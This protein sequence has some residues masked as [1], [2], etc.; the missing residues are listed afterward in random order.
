MCGFTGF[1]DSH[2]QLSASDIEPIAQKMQLQLRDRGPDSS[3]IWVDP[4]DGIAMTHRR[5]A[6][7]DL[8]EHGHQPMLSHDGRY[9]L[10]FNGEIFNAEELREKL[11]SRGVK[12]RGHADTEILLEACAHYGVKTTLEQC[13]GM[14]AIALWDRQEKT[15]T[16]A[17][18]R[19]GKK[20]L[21]WGFQNRILFFGS[22][23]K[24]FFVHPSWQNQLDF[25]ATTN[26]FRYGYVPTTQSIFKHLAQV[27]PGHLIHLRHDA[28]PK[29]E[30]YWSL[31]QHFHPDRKIA[32]S[33][34]QS[35]IEDELHDLLVDTVKMRMH[36]DV[37]IGSFLSGGIDSS[38]VTALMQA[39]HPTPIHTFSIGFES[40]P[41]NEAPYAE[42]VAHY[43]GTEH[44]T[45]YVAAHEVRDVIDRL[46]EIY[47]EPFADSS[48]I[49]TFLVAQF[50]KEKV[51]V[52]LSGDGGDESF[53]GYNRYWMAKMYW[54]KVE[55]IPYILRRSLMVAQ[56]LP[57]WAWSWLS[58]LHSKRGILTPDK[59]QRK[60]GALCSKN[61]SEFYRSLVLSL[62]D[63]AFLSKPN[64]A[65]DPILS[66]GS[67]LDSLDLVE[68]MQLIDLQTYLPG[69][70][71][72]KVDRASMAVGLEARA[73]L[74]DHRLIE[75]ATQLPL[76]YKLRGQEGKWI[77]RNV[78]ARY[79]PRHLF[80]RPKMGFG[81][82][83]AEWLRGPLRAW[84]EPL[85]HDTTTPL[86]EFL[87][88]HQIQRCW[89]EHLSG[90]QEWHYPLWTVLMFQSWCHYWNIRN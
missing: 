90:Q 53:A 81:I 52:V 20:P 55:K 39:Q 44:H 5:L 61:A 8:S 14:F 49:P 26:Y 36:A 17:R 9:V 16:L 43:L 84:A 29:I 78:L 10:I 62:H 83:L 11:I 24:S 58:R 37:P 2:H 75:F 7:M 88:V 32:T 85:I 50:A 63:D 68:R 18:D 67:K 33:K 60:L 80:E 13:I 46:P 57:S 69:D 15:L 35:T 73:P 72:V 22:Q 86:S 30:A 34:S 54:S 25:S 89:K 4:A 64:P 56:Y 6:I 38:L 87:N 45:H 70:I 19:I 12:F 40:Q 66:L 1:W 74:L 31:E 41:Y 77:L 65:E 51:K 76:E 28:S 48:Q 27:P 82:P 42:K 3:G 79:L 59:I 47:D 23:P 71:L 21:Y